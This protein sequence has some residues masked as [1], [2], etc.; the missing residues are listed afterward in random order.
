M[1]TWRMVFTA[2]LLGLFCGALQMYPLMSF[3]ESKLCLREVVDYFGLIEADYSMLYLGEMVVSYLPILVF[4]VL[5]GNVIYKNFCVAGIYYFT[6]TEK[7]GVWIAKEALKTLCFSV[8]YAL[9]TIISGFVVCNCYGKLIFEIDKITVFEFFSYIILVSLFVYITTIA[10]NSF[11]ILTESGLGFVISEAVIMFT[12]VC[13]CAYKD[14]FGE[15]D[16]TDIHSWFLKVNPFRHLI[17]LF[18]ISP[19]NHI[20]SMIYF[21]IIAFMVTTFMVVVIRK[22]EFISNNQELDK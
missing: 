3:Y 11:A 4:H 17:F 7:I 1:K 2:C 8:L 16:T 13:F 19:I 14:L 5:F 21:L 10:I 22:H 20:K 12:M 6:R 9:C 18:K 15:Y